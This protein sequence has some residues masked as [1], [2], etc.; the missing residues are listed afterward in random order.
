MGWIFLDYRE[1]GMSHA[2]FFTRELLGSPGEGR[3]S[4]IIE[5]A[6][7]PDDEGSVFYAAVAT[8]SGSAPTT[9]VWALIVL[10]QGRA[11]ARFGWKALDETMGPVQDGCPARVLDLLSDT[12]NRIAFAW[13]ERCRQRLALLA[14][15]VAG[16]T[17]EFGSEYLTPTGP[18][19]RFTVVDSDRSLFSAP[20]S[21]PYRLLGW[22]HSNF[23]VMEPTS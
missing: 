11:G 13:R 4:R 9:E 8:E 17:V 1:P 14:L 3:R 19:R 22:R 2:Q 16:A 10:T 5:S 6:Y 7:V 15:A 23:T 12:D 18:Y 21:T 20:D